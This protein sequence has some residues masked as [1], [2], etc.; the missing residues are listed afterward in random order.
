MI[1]NGK[2]NQLFNQCPLIKSYKIQFS[3]DGKNLVP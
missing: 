2:S 1:I 3:F